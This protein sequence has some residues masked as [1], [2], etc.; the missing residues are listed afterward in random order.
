MILRRDVFGEAG[1]VG[2]GR[3]LKGRCDL[4]LSVHKSIQRCDDEW[5]GKD[6]GA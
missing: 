1:V 2:D 4:R 6:K 5:R 3:W